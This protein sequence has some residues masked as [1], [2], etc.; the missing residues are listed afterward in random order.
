[1]K[2]EDNR[3]SICI[4]INRKDKYHGRPLYKVLIKKFREMQVS[5]CTLL[6][7]L[8]SYGSNFV[9]HPGRGPAFLKNKGLLLHIVET[10]KKSAEILAVIENY[11][12]NGMITL[13][14]VRMFRY[15]AKKSSKED[16]KLIDHT[17]SIS[18]GNPS[19]D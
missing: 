4:Y 14:P 1:M 2:F 3:V 12:Y 17:G 15:T 18:L 8:E 16:E 11:I 6:R 19:L 13:N 7:S 10:E 9:L 5:G